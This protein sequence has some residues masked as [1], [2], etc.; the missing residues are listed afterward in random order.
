[1][2]AGGKVVG[3]VAFSD[4]LIEQVDSVA[5]RADTEIR[6]TAICAAGFCVHVGR[7]LLSETDAFAEKEKGVA[8]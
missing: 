4:S 7:L 1:L 2:S 8:L 6:Y 5:V 3:L